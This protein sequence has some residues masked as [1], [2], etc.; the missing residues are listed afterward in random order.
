[1]QAA[2]PDILHQHHESFIHV[3]LLVAM[4]QGKT[5]VVRYEIDFDALLPGH[6]HGILDD[7]SHGLASDLGQ[8]KHVAM[9]MDRMP[10]AALVVHHQAI[11]LAM[12]DL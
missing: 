3:I 1:V 6:L 7:T 2:R 10:V 9:Q 12:Q 11:M 5:R 8:L 4:K